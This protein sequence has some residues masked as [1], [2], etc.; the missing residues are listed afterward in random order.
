MHGRSPI[1][2]RRISRDEAVAATTVAVLIN[3][4]RNQRTAVQIDICFY[5]GCADPGSNN[6]ITT[7][8]YPA[9]L[10]YSAELTTLPL[11][12]RLTATPWQSG[13]F[14]PRAEQGTIAGPLRHLGDST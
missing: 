7:D 11:A 12:I 3:K 8:L 5:L 14:E 6:P 13:D 1:C 2:L 4:T 10:D 9:R